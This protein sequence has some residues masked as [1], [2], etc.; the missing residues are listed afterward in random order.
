MNNRDII[1]IEIRNY[2][3]KN[4]AVSPSYIVINRDDYFALKE[5]V[6]YD[7]DDEIILFAGCDVLITMNLTEPIRVM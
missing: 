6:G 1:D 7:F 4:A 2:K 5:E 3:L